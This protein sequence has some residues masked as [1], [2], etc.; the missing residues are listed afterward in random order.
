MC[1]VFLQN[2]SVDRSIFRSVISLYRA[3]GA[4]TETALSLIRRR[5]RGMTRLSHAVQIVR[6]YRRLVSASPRCTPACIQEVT[7]E[8]KHG[9]HPVSKQTRKAL[10]CSAC[11]QR[12]AVT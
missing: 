9:A 10:A 5:V 6:V 4:A 2:E 11:V 8:L 7:C 3:R 12:L 1:S